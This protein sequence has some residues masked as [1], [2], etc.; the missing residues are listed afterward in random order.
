MT[1]H[2][3]YIRNDIVKFKEIHNHSLPGWLW[4]SDEFTDV[5]VPD[6]AGA[7]LPQMMILHVNLTID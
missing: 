4:D 7:G 2:H 3:Q 6:L 1:K 5:E